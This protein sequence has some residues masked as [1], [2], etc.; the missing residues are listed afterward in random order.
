MTLKRKEN[1]PDAV[2]DLIKI[3]HITF[4]RTD[5]PPNKIKPGKTKKLQGKV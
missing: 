1:R 4:G 3:S 5:F 2:I